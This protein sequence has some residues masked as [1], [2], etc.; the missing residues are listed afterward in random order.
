MDRPD[1]VEIIARETAYEGHFRLDRYRLRHRL[2]DGGMSPELKREVFERGHAAALLPYDP[3]RDEVAGAAPSRRSPP[4]SG[5][6]S[7]QPLE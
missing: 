4:P 2:F 6:A 7:T 5:A 3:V 1:D